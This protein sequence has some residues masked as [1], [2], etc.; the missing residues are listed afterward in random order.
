M[1]VFLALILDAVVGE[2]RA[3][4]SRIPH[5]AVLMGRLIGTCDTAFN[6]GK[7]RRAKGTIVIAMLCLLAVLSG[8]AI[9]AAFGFWGEVII[10]AILIAH[11]SLVQHV[12]A[13]GDA[14]RVSLGDGKRAVA[15]IV[16]RDTKDMDGSDVARSAI[17]SAAEN[18]SDGVTAPVFWFAILGL[19]GLILYKIINTADSMIGYKTDRHLEFGWAAA[20]FDDL[21]NFVPARLTAAIICALGSRT[22]WNTIATE[23]KKHRSPNAGW[24]EAAMA[25]KLGIAL[26]GPRS[27]F[28]KKTTDPFVNPTGVNNLTPD[29]IDQA[30]A[31]LW[32][33]WIAL[34]VLAALVA[35]L[36]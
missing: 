27:Y 17:E 20:R 9:S 30:T 2:P 33:T 15:M 21:L 19:K 7:N 36:V 10:G 32:Q 28:G 14:L 23:A 6:Q 11:K 12:S 16:G 35:F 5:P 34:V 1:T 22:G 26:S 18:L 4:W 3:I 29:H 8:V 24:P 31:V 25:Y 13:V